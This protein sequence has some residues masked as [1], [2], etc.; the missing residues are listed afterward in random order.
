MVSQPSSQSPITPVIVDNV[1]YSCA[2]SF[3]RLFVD[4]TDT[5]VTIDL[6]SNPSFNDEIEIMNAA[7]SFKNNNVFVN[8]NGEHIMGED[9]IFTIDVNSSIKFVFYNSG[10]G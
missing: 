7:N 5:T 8:P 4:T 1:D 3:L 10:F 6:P 2:S 9:V